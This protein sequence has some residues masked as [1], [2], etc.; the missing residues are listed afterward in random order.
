M[1]NDFKLFLQKK[2]KSPQTIINTRF[3]S[4]LDKE[5]SELKNPDFCAYRTNMQNGI[6]GLTNLFSEFTGWFASQMNENAKVKFA[7]TGK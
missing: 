5:R 6:N 2:K 7:L 3:S 4:I 1:F